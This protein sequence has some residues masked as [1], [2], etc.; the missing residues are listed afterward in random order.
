M[1]RKGARQ[2]PARAEQ[3]EK[4]DGRVPA[5]GPMSGSSDAK[6]GASESTFSNHAGMKSKIKAESKREELSAS[7]GRKVRASK[8][9][10]RVTLQLQSASTRR[11]AGTTV[12]MP[13][14]ASHTAGRMTETERSDQDTG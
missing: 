11:A 6:L 8:K 10:G 14:Q 4:G 9:T 7:Q 5:K 13:V 3:K 1:N 12:L 2:P